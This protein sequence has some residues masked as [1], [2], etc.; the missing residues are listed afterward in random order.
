MPVVRR[1]PAWLLCQ[2]GLLLAQPLTTVGRRAGPLDWGWRAERDPA[3]PATSR[4]EIS[5]QYPTLGDDSR[6]GA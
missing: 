2:V 3:S 4:A 1:V 6:A 5:S